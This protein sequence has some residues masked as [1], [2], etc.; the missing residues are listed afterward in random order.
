MTRPNPP[1]KTFPTPTPGPINP[2]DETIAG[3][4]RDYRMAALDEA[5][6]HADPLAQF[7]QW[8]TEAL[9]AQ[10]QEANA[11]A[12]ASV[13]ADGRPS[14]RVLLLKGI[15]HGGFTFY[16]NYESRKGREF[17]ANPWAA[18]T[19]LWYPLERQVRVE[20]RV[21][22]VSA[23]ES[24]AY[25]AIRPLDS[26]IGAWASPQSEVIESRQ[27]LEDNQ[28]TYRQRFGDAPLRPAHWGGYRLMPE[29]IE[30]WQ[31]RPSRLHDR[32]RYRR[33]ADLWR[34]DRLAS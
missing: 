31:G 23:A 3:L 2:P 22:R 26:R 32:I 8:F 10:L 18:L 5:N 16:T 14:C 7:E 11:M 20:G 13:D 27:V 24:D 28:A 15:E 34:I 21:E 19:F 30:F 9:S 6:V 29:M 1:G 12:V 17:A 4:R 25:F 33:D